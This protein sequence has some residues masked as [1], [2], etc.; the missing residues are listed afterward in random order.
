MSE[1]TKEQDM[2]SES[3]DGTDNKIHR[4]PDYALSK[5]FADRVGKFN[6][7]PLSPRWLKDNKYFWYRANNDPGADEDFV[8]VDVEKQER[9]LAFDHDKLAEAL[10]KEGVRPQLEDKLPFAAINP[11]IDG[12]IVR[13]RTGTD[14]WQVD[15]DSTLSKFEGEIDEATLV[16]LWKEISSDTKGTPSSVVFFNNTTK[17]ISLL[18]MDYSDRA[19]PY[20]K[21]E[22]G[23]SDRRYTY[24]GHVWRIVDEETQERIVSFQASG[25]DAIA[26]IE[27]RMRSEDYQ[28]MQHCRGACLAVEIE[29]GRGLSHVYPHLNLEPP[30]SF[31]FFIKD[32]I[33]WM[34]DADGKETR[35]SKGGSKNNTWDVDP[36]YCPNG[37]YVVECSY[38]P[39]Q[40][41]KIHH[42]EY[43]PSDQLEPKLKETQYTKAGDQVKRDRPRMFDLVKKKEIKFDDALYSKPFEMWHFGWN[44]DGTE[45]RFMYNERGHQT[46]RVISLHT[47][48]K[49]RVCIEEISR[50]F[51]DYSSKTRLYKWLSKTDEMIWMSERDGRNH[52]Y[53]YNFGTSK[54]INQITKGDYTVYEIDR[55]DKDT[56][57]IWFNAL[58]LVKGRDP[59]YMQLAR[60][61]FDGSDLTVLM[62]DNGSHTW[63]WS[64]DLKYLISTHSRIDHAPETVLRDAQTGKILLQ[65]EERSLSPLLQTG[66]TLPERFAAP[67]RDGKTMIYGLIIRPSNLDP[68]KRYPIIEQIYAGPHDFHVKKSFV[69]HMIQ[70]TLAE[71]GFIIVMI[72]G[73]GTN[74]RTKAFHDVCYKNLKD[75]GLPDRIPWIKAAA[76]TRPWMD[77]ERVGI[78]GGSAGGQ[79]ALG[80]L[81]WHG[82]F[83]KAAV[84]NNGCHDNRIDKQ[85]WGEQWLGYPVDESYADNSNV[86]HAHRLRGKLLL[87][88]S[89]LDMNVDPACSMQVAAA[90]NEAEKDYELLF[91]PGQGH[92]EETPYVKRRVQDFFVRELMG[93]A[94]PERNLEAPRKKGGKT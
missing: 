55:V 90:L 13:F 66:W 26:I 47:T 29:K 30:H 22:P 75:G 56:R 28:R 34:R 35:L 24:E 5:S 21:I 14:K 82:D 87:I 8:F 11:T 64:P 40:D 44:L 32:H 59:Y 33:A 68:S 84:A 60:I 18:W 42:I 4:T 57:Q 94:V 92:C 36:S 38:K 83:Y 89:E 76:K 91:L 53:L 41:H 1:R 72:D 3:K 54:L 25:T 61:N 23:K 51:I 48:G 85:W 80:A 31:H 62:D 86:V 70:H 50:T 37:R 77:I 71:L 93:G 74:W 17:P 81:L 20:A 49:V 39:E 43:K 79:N 19:K 10:Q 45:Y 65:L 73:M 69:L 46:V 88:V 58:G 52:L 15:E 16:P 2:M 67:G 78:T 12:K 27:Q 9:R 6:F 63:D 7:L